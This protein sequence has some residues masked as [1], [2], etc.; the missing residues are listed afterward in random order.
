MIRDLAIVTAARWIATIKRLGEFFYTYFGAILDYAVTLSSRV[1]ILIALM[2]NLL[3]EF[4]I[5]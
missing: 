4:A 1:F 5:V 3:N 2:R